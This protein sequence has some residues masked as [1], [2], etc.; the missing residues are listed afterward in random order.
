M[1]NSTLIK[2]AIAVT[3]LL[4]ITGICDAGKTSLYTLLRFGEKRSTVS[5]MKENEG[6]LAIS[7]KLIRRSMLLIYLVMNVFAIV[8]STF[9]L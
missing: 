3:I 6:Q 8:M 5:S 4:L 2:A 7:N 1:D 9:Y